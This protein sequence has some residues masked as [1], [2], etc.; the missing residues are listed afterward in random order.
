[1]IIAKA[2]V[3]RDEDVIFVRPTNMHILEH[4]WL[5]T[6]PWSVHKELAILGRSWQELSWE[7]ASCIST[8]PSLQQNAADLVERGS[9]M[10]F[11]WERCVYLHKRSL[12]QWWRSDVFHG[13]DTKRLKG[14]RSMRWLSYISERGSD[15]SLQWKVSGYSRLSDTGRKHV[16]YRS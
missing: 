9:W 13:Q 10:G 6:E 12:G 2:A 1:M 7:T 11:E 8:H 16:G 5:R 15:F 4:W 14:N 3:R